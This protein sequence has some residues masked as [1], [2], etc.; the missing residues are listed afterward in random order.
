MKQAST[1]VAGGAGCALLGGDKALQLLKPILD[2][3]ELSLGG[4]CFGDSLIAFDHQEALAVG[5]YV[6]CGAVGKVR[7]IDTLK[8]APWSPWIERRG[9][10]DDPTRETAQPILLGVTP[11]DPITVVAGLGEVVCQ[12]AD[13]CSVLRRRRLVFHFT[14]TG[15]GTTLHVNHEEEVHTRARSGERTR[16]NSEGRHGCTNV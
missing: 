7:P 15:L 6:P 5:G 11:V 16:R 9:R 3:D 4:Y 14:S 13:R 2:E 1:G 12:L 8:Q 10:E